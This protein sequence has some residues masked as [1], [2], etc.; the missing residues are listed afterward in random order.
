M[1]NATSEGSKGAEGSHLRK[2]SN[3]GKNQVS[4][5][6]ERRSQAPRKGN[7]RADAES[8]EQNPKMSQRKCGKR[9]DLREGSRRCQT[10]R[11]L[12]AEIRDESI[13]LLLRPKEGSPLSNQEG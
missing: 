4:N 3:G 8:Q 5:E 6:A 7:L 10:S 11:R 2:E 1:R 9:S 12:R 13:Q